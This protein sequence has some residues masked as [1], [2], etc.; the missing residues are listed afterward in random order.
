MPPSI[1]RYPRD[2][3][4]SACLALCPRAA[5]SACASA[6]SLRRQSSAA[7]VLSREEISHPLQVGA[8]G[9]ETGLELVQDHLGA[10]FPFLLVRAADGTPPTGS[11]H[12]RSVT[13][14]RSARKANSSTTCTSSAKGPQRKDATVLLRLGRRGRGRLPS[15]RRAIVTTNA[16]PQ[17]VLIPR[18]SRQST[19][20]KGIS[21]KPCLPPVKVW[22]LGSNG[23]CQPRRCDGREDRVALLGAAPEDDV[24][25]PT[26]GLHKGQQFS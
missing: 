16:Q 26:K 22:Q 20:V 11:G 7:Q 17:L 10:R 3:R 21:G 18:L 24:L 12:T 5:D 14:A 19:H 9:D 23:L 25:A 8:N 6:A 4:S 13:L 15:Q 1:S 2:L